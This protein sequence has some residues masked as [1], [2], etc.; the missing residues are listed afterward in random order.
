MHKI[1]S[2]SYKLNLFNLN[3]F[4][5]VSFMGLL[6]FVNIYYRLYYLLKHSIHSR[7]H[8][9]IKLNIKMYKRYVHASTLGY[10][11]S[12]YILSPRK[13]IRNLKG[14]ALFSNWAIAILTIDYIMDD[15]NLDYSTSIQF[16][17]DF[18][19]LMSGRR[20]YSI[21]YDKYTFHRESKSLKNALRI[22]K[23]FGESIKKWDTPLKREFLDKL[24]IFLDGQ[25]STILQKEFSMAQDYNW[26]WESLVNQKSVYFYLAPL[27]LFSKTKVERAR[28]NKIES[29]FKK[30]NQCYYHWQLLDDVVDYRKDLNNGVNAGP[31]YLLIL[32]GN[33]ANQILGMI[34]KQSIFELRSLDNK[35]ILQ[36]LLNTFLIYLPAKSKIVFSKESDLILMIKVALSNT[37]LEEKMEL[38]EL[39][40]LKVANR[41]S[42]QKFISNSNFK[43]AINLIANS[44]VTNVIVNEALEIQNVAQ[45]KAISS[46]FRS[47]LKYALYAISLLIHKTYLNANK[48]I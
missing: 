38:E 10:L 33:F 16:I 12:A 25:H 22:C 18:K 40:N 6:F 8:K 28:L 15:L 21:N 23:N 37:K 4:Q 41:D 27:T 39:L 31:V 5:I 3:K 9:K 32:Q 47:S 24:E 30:L 34:H 29:E 19:N 36:D 35:K 42:I 7:I 17:E 13:F 2:S 48:K 20:S 44:E 1:L 46:E 45:F 43:E 11:A 14:G 26:Y